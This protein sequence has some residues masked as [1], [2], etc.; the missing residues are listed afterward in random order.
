MINH[1]H[2]KRVS[3]VKYMSRRFFREGFEDKKAGLPFREIKSTRDSLTYERGRMLAA[4]APYLSAIKNG[5]KVRVDAIV[6]AEDAFYK[7]DIL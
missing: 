1:N 4:T 6:A 7:K 3:M 2:T 5:R